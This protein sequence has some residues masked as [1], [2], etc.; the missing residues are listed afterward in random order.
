MRNFW[1]NGLTR[2][3]VYPPKGSKIIKYVLDCDVDDKVTQYIL[4]LHINSEPTAEIPSPPQEPKWEGKVRPALSEEEMLN[5]SDSELSK[6]G[7]LRRPNVDKSSNAF[8]IW[9]RSVS[10]PARVHEP[11]TTYQQRNAHSLVKSVND[12]SSKNINSFTWAGSELRLDPLGLNP[13]YYFI[14]GSCDNVPPDP[15]PEGGSTPS[16]V[17][18]WVGIDG[19]SDVGG[20]GSDLVQAGISMDN[21]G[22]GLT[23]YYAWYEFIPNLQPEQELPQYDLPIGPGYHLWVTCTVANVAGDGSVNAPFGP[24]A[25]NVYFTWESLAPGASHW[26]SYTTGALSK[27]EGTGGVVSPPTY[28]PCHTAEWIVERPTI[29]GTNNLWDLLNFGSVQMSGYVSTNPPIGTGDPT[30]PRNRPD[31]PSATIRGIVNAGGSVLASATVQTIDP[32]TGA[33]TVTWHNSH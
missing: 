4:E 25:P 30:D 28:T 16:H 21:S 17:S 29:P 6:R 8:K 31:S 15:G 5:L 32:S 24:D 12:I 14:F 2:F 3:Y 27:G 23:N 1:I 11:Q 19:D 26:D 7:Y 20:T 9:R 33:V 18:I 22:T 13:V 10:L